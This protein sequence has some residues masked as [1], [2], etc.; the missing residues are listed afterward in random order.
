MTQLPL[1]LAAP[2]VHLLVQ[3]EAGY[4][5]GEPEGGGRGGEAR[6][7][8]RRVL[9]DHPLRATRGGGGA[10]L[11]AVRAREI[12]IVELQARGST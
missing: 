10:Q 4:R 9:P 11:G 7:V 8:R 12:R 5:V 2:H 1:P 6:A 3:N